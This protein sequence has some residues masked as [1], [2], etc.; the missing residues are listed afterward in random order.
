MVFL[1]QSRFWAIG[2]AGMMLGVG[3]MIGLIL[4]ANFGWLIPGDTSTKPRFSPVFSKTDEP[5]ARPG[6][7]S[8][9][10]V[11]EFAT[12]AVVN[13]STI[14]IVRERGN[15]PRAPFFE[16]PFFREFFGEDFLKPFELP[17]ERSEQ[18]LGSGVIVDSDGLIVT[19]NHVVAK[20]DEIKVLLGDKR[21]YSG[22]VIG[23]D[24]IFIYHPIL[25]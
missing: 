1:K 19:N 12:P 20:A 13:I 17:R 3:I 18:S 23:T 16:D 15:G 9:V 21:E 22:R 8:F 4:A 10:G 2:V 7:N 6:P 11:A 25:Q 24:P 14:R 5:S